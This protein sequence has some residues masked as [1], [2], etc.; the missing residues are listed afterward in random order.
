MTVNLEEAVGLI[1]QVTRPWG[2][3]IRLG[4]IWRCHGLRV[5]RSC[6][7]VVVV[8]GDGILNHHGGLVSFERPADDV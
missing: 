8:P 2:E 7:R 1:A 6:H 4:V 5:R 3:V